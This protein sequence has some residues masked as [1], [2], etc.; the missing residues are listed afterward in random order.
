MS[1]GNIIVE[2]FPLDLTLLIFVLSCFTLKVFA[3]VRR[4]V[5]LYLRAGNSTRS[6]PSTLTIWPL[7]FHRAVQYA[8]MIQRFE[9]P[10]LIGTLGG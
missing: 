5:S 8:E 10:S 4:V 1:I 3:L 7:I 2:N 9:V 6:P